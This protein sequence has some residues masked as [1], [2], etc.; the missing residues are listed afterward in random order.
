MVKYNIV[1][2]SDIL[3]PNYE[4]SYVNEALQSCSLVDYFIFTK[5]P[6]LR[7]ISNAALDDLPNL[8]D[9][10]PLTLTISLPEPVAYNP[11]ESKNLDSPK[12]QLRW[13]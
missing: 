1:L 9:H 2:A 13:D 5:S 4:F 12:Y 11:D 6:N 7:I 10:L 8:S 3:K